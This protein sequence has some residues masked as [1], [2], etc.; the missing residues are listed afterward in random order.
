MPV[1]K[2]LLNVDVCLALGYEGTYSSEESI[3]IVLKD[4]VPRLGNLYLAGLGLGSKHLL[5]CIRAQDVGVGSTH[6]QG[7]TAETPPGRP[8]V[9]RCG[10]ALAPLLPNGKIVAP[11]NLAVRQ[12]FRGVL[13]APSEDF[14][15][16]VAVLL[17]H[18]GHHG[19]KRLELLGHRQN[20]LANTRT[21]L[22]V[23]RRADINDDELLHLLGIASAE[24][25]A[26]TT[27]QGVPN[28]DKGVEVQSGGDIEEVCDIRGRRIDA[29]LGPLA[30]AAAALVQGQNVVVFTQGG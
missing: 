19:F 6:N 24:G 3:R 27:A 1:F 2:P 13:Q 5:A 14:W 8:E 20:L 10:G 7:G 28:Q 11:A 21:A 25:N 29:V 4:H 12:R 17:A 9:F 22:R 15:S 26:V 23:C 30:I 16:G 18:V